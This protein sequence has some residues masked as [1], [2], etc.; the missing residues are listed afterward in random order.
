MAL[1]FQQRDDLCD[2]LLAQRSE[3]QGQLGAMPCSDIVP[4]LSGQ[5]Q[6]GYIEGKGANDQV[7]DRERGLVDLQ[8]RER[9]S[10][11]QVE[12]D[13]K[14]LKGDDQEHDAGTAE[15]VGYPVCD[16]LKRAS[17]HFMLTMQLSHLLHGGFDMIDL[18]RHHVE[19]HGE[20]IVAD[21]RNS[22]PAADQ[23][24]SY[25]PTRTPLARTCPV[26]AFTTALRPGWPPR[27]NARSSAKIW[28]T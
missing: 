9:T 13:P 12:G 11:R 23:A 1:L 2:L 6:K 4:P 19:T 15:A 17:L 16:P 21:R 5:D 3:L 27:F 10:R 14:T 7:Q 18:F 25:T 22:P 28:N 26:I 20:E 24:R 8:T